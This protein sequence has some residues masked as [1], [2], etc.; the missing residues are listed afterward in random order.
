MLEAFAQLFL[1]RPHKAKRKS[2]A[3]F[4]V[5]CPAAFW[6]V[7]VS[8]NINLSQLLQGQGGVI[9]LLMRIIS[10]F[11]DQHRIIL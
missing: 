3:F 8:R 6:G 5:I 10:S 9:Y 4:F 1:R 11:G 2:S 7:E